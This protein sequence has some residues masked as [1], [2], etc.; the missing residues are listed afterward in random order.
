MTIHHDFTDEILNILEEE[1]SDAAEEI[2]VASELIQYLN[3]KTRSASRGS[4]SRGAFGNHYALYVLV[5]R[6]HRQ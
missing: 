2:F 5:E 6:L 4:K 1:F 3:V